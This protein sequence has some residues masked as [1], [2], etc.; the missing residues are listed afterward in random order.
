MT[1]ARPTRASFSTSRRT[2][3]ARASATA[4]RSSSGT[5]C[6]SPRPGLAE[7]FAEGVT[8]QGVDVVHIG[9]ASTDML[10][11]ASGTLDLPGA[12]FTASH[13]PAKY[14]GIKL[15][16]AGAS[17]VGQDTGLDEI[18]RAARAAAPARWRV[19][20][21]HRARSATATCSPTTRPTCARWSTSRASARCR[22]SSTPAT[23]WAAT[24]CPRVRWPAPIEIVPL[25]FE[26]D[27]T[28]PNHEANPLD[29]K[30]LVDLQARWSPSAGA[31]AGLAFDGDAD[32]C[33]VVDEKGDAGEPERDHRAGRG[34]RAGEGTRARPSSTT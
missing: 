15:C 5:T 3:P 9:L 28:F 20:P 14:N 33:F 18:R 10:Y 30:N 22:S 13:N 17:P 7:A 12:M 19:T 11:F 2:A 27:G 32:R 6:A 34:A 26:L 25:Y 24:R 31:D 29:P 4:A 8:A 21:Q 1:S 23:A 16:R